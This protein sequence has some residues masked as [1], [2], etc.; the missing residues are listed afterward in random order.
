[1]YAAVSNDYPG[2]VAIGRTRNLVGK[3]GRLDGKGVEIKLAFLSPDPK[4]AEKAI[5]GLLRSRHVEG[6]W[7]RAGLDELHPL[8]EHLNKLE[9]AR[10]RLLANIASFARNI[11][12][13]TGVPPDSSGNSE[14][15]P[16]PSA[17]RLLMREET[18]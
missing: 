14:R 18:A 7:H 9:L 6:E 5:R 4:D 1:M 8:F 12:R 15:L 11:D 10:W 16:P 13:A 3:A 2:K 17:M